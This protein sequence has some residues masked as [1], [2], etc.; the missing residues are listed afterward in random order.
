MAILIKQSSLQKSVSKFTPKKFYE[1]V[2]RNQKICPCRNLRTIQPSKI[3]ADIFFIYVKKVLCDL[4]KSSQLLKLL[5][6]TTR[7][8]SK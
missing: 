7:K 1:I 6:H 4:F 2:L 8:S 3:Y 5:Q